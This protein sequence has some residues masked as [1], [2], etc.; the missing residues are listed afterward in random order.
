MKWFLKFKVIAIIL[1]I[2]SFYAQPSKAQKSN[3]GLVFIITDICF[4][5]WDDYNKRWENNDW[6][7]ATG[8]IKVKGNS[9]T[10]HLN[11]PNETFVFDLGPLKT[12]GKK[13]EPDGDRYSY[14][15]FPVTS[16]T[17]G[18]AIFKA[19]TSRKGFML[20]L[21]LNNKRLSFDTMD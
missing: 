14:S 20:I 21:V 16:G 6:V 12:R 13:R 5:L 8:W 1:L 4:D 18:L 15:T 2:T 7:P 9:L 10:V 11:N 3:D 19:Y 17:G